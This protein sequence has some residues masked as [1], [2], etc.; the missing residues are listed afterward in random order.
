M[1]YREIIGK[2][3]D[4]LD[5]WET[6]ATDT[7]VPHDPELAK[8]SILD[9][10]ELVRETIDYVD[11]GFDIGTESGVLIDVLLECKALGGIA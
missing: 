1:S 11:R 7:G 4:R 9:L 6:V 5:E 3:H 2:I 8:Q 10:V